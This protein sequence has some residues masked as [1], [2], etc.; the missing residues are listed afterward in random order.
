MRG[1]RMFGCFFGSGVFW[2]GVP[3]GW[4][5]RPSSKG[6]PARSARAYSIQRG[7]SPLKN[8]PYAQAASG[9]ARTK[10]IRETNAAARSAAV[11]AFPAA[12]GDGGVS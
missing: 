9:V 1:L 6:R 10:R 3:G 4:M 5:G 7:A 8:A 2:Y 11:R 12:G